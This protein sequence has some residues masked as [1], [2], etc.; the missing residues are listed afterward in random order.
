M[1]AFFAP[2][3]IKVLIFIKF[4]IPPQKMLKSAQDNFGRSAKFSVEYEL[5]SLPKQDFRP[6]LRFILM[7]SS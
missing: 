7:E 2:D 1:S 4:L 3:H 5:Y 6:I